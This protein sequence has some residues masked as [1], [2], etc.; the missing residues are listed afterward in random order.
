MGTTRLKYL[1]SNSWVLF[2]TEY[3]ILIQQLQHILFIHVVFCTIWC[4]KQDSTCQMIDHDILDEFVDDEDPENNDGKILNKWSLFL[5]IYN[6]FRW[7]SS[8]PKYLTFR[9]PSTCRIYTSKLFLR[10]M[11]ILFKNYK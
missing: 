3:C 8:T 11:N 1:I 4:K 7:C 10:Q 6:I 9:T 5:L 2:D